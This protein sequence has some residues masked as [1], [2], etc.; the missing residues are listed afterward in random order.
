MSLVEPAKTTVAVDGFATQ[1]DLGAVETDWN[2]QAKGKGANS[3]YV[4]SVCFEAAGDATTGLCGTPTAGSA[5]G[6]IYVTYQDAAGT[7]V[8][9]NN[10]IML[11]Y[12]QNGAGKGV[13]GSMTLADQLSSAAESGSL[14]W[15]C[16]SAGNT[17]AKANIDGAITLLGTVPQKYVP[18]NCR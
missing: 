18:A 12:V 10:I 15:A 6:N 13:N 3:K 4:S 5:T 8:S 11:P 1:N 7:Q 17:Y 9:G 14:D 2:G 16:V